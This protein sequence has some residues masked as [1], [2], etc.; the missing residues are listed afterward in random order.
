MPREMCRRVTIGK[1]SSTVMAVS[2]S[3]RMASIEARA[4][5]GLQRVTACSTK[6]METFS[7]A[8]SEMA[9]R[10]DRES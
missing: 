9:S 2:L 10:S 1:V 6:I 8:F 3:K 7:P 4:K 5:M